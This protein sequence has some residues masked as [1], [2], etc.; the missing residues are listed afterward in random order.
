MLTMVGVLRKGNGSQEEEGSFIVF[1]TFMSG[2]SV[3]I[4]TLINVIFTLK[5]P[6]FFGVY[7]HQKLIHF[8]S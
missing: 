6:P 8:S 3:C 5:R 7:Y 2:F 4:T 1:S